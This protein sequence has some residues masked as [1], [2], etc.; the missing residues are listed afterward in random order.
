M[1]R[2]RLG[3]ISSRQTSHGSERRDEVC[4]VFQ[5]QMMKLVSAGLFFLDEILVITVVIEVKRV[6]IHEL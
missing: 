4:L 1:I 3:K 5:L 6:I 2:L